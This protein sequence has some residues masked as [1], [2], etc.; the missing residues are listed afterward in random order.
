MKNSARSIGLIFASSLLAGCLQGPEARTGP[1]TVFGPAQEINY[2]SGKKFKSVTAGEYILTVGLEER[3]VPIYKLTKPLRT[4][5]PGTLGI[6]FDVEIDPCVLEPKYGCNDGIAFVA[7]ASKCRATYNGTS[8]FGKDDEIGIRVDKSKKRKLIFVDN[9]RSAGFPSGYIIYKRTLSS[10]EEPL[11]EASASSRTFWKG[12]GRGIIYGGA[13]NG[14]LVIIYEE[15][16]ITP[17]G[18]NKDVERELQFDIPEDGVT[19]IS[20]RGAEL[21]VS[22]ADSQALEYRIV[23]AFNQ[24]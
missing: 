16:L 2:L 1:N 13:A 6:P 23:K 20:I 11:F 15:Y 22:R 21:E 10:A 5:V 12:K 24:N 9:G 4:T 14:R 8:V 17:S 18:F 7:P 19:K 3:D